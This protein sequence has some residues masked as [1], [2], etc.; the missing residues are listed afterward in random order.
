M[1]AEKAHFPVALMCRWLEV[2]RSGF[3]AWCRR[4]ESAWAVKNRQ[5]LVRIRTV[6]ERARGAYGSPRVHAELKAEGVHVGRRRVARLM[7]E[8][9]LRARKARRFVR[10]TQ[11]SP[12]LK[13]A[14]NALR[15]QFDPLRPNQ[16]W[17]GDI[18]YIP[19]RQG[20]LY[21]AV[22][23]DLFSRRVVG[24]SMGARIDT[25]LT[26][27]ALDMA[28]STRQSARALLHHSDRGV[29]YAC[30]AYRARLAEH[31][32]RCSMSRKGNCWD[33]AVVESFFAS[34]KTELVHHVDFDDQREA[35]HAV[36]QYIEAFY[37]RQR[38]HSSLDYM[39]P[40]QYEDF[41]G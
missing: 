28:L 40:V 14:P 24:W 17:A 2:G 33:N 22:I 9:G 39:S 34:L 25:Q 8:D 36:F 18:T 31:G 23:L 13:P 10:T 41:Y 11:S 37:N 1:Q 29:Q 3:Y 38:R 16:V 32:I 26:L 30:D 35:Q 12:S 6:H 19:T 21:L 15:R 5:L 27:R 4:G 20:W 7:R